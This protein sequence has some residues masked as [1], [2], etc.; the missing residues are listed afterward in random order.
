MAKFACN[1]TGFSNTLWNRVM[2]LQELG[3]RGKLS[4]RVVEWLMWLG[5]CVAVLHIVILRKF[6]ISGSQGLLKKKTGRCRHIGKSELVIRPCN[7]ING[8]W[9]ALPRRC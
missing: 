7:Q 9:H 5:K 3:Q 1:I 2:P 6:R 8:F 4:Y